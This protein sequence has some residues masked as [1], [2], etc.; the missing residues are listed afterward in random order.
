MAALT[1]ALQSISWVTGVEQVE[2]CLRVAAPVDRSAELNGILAGQGVL[3]A[4]LST[5]ETA[6][7]DVL[8]LS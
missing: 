2:G 8:P 3:L 4:E 1:Q 6:L 7:E 5:W